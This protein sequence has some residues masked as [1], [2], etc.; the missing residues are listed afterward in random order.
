MGVVQRQS[1]KNT[2]SS[3]FGIVLGFVSLILIQPKFLQPEEIGLVRVLFAFS[4]LLASFIPMGATNLSIKYF[5]IFKNEKNGHNGFLGLVLLFPLAGYILVAAGLF[6]FKEFIIAQYRRE[7]PL[8][9]EYYNYIFVFSLVLAF[10]S[11]L[12]TYLISLYKTTVPSYLNDVY[13]RIAYLAL[14]FVYYFQYIDFKQFIILYIGIFALQLLLLIAYLLKE[15]KPSLRINWRIYKEKGLKEMLAFSLLLAASAIAILGLKTLDAVMIG[16]FLPLSFVGIYTIASFIPTIIEAPY[17]ALDRIATARVAHAVAEN[18]IEELR[19]VFY[20]SVKY[21]GIIGGLLF[22]GVNGSI[23]YVLRLIGGDY[24]NGLT[25][26]WI[27][28]IGSLINM[29][30]G[31]NYGLI[32]YSAKYWVA[33]VIAISMV[34]FTFAL[35]MILIPRFGLEGA[36]F[37]T[38]VSW[39]G[40]AMVRVFIINRKFGFQPYD[41]NTLKTIAVVLICVAISFILPELNGNITNIIFRSAVIGCTYLALTYYLNILPEFHHYLPWHKSR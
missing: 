5:P 2:I 31:S 22:V 27:I 36:A 23:E 24:V 19:T 30:G 39:G 29:M 7:S 20:K 1:I 14:I 41:L 40:Y 12:T 15:D 26:V 13:V 11:V 34:V 8:F 32:I 17:N 4:T 28:S 33:A 16:K 6:I 35:D 38:A 9:I 25:V 37:A 18:N 21:L 3:Y 10:T